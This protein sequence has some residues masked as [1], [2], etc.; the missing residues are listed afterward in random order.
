MSRRPGPTAAAWAAV[1]GLYLVA[2]LVSP[3][4]FQVSQVLNILQVAAF[5][6]LIATGQTLVILIGGIDLAQAGVVTLT[7]IVATSIM[8]GDAGNIPAAVLACLALAALVGMLN[9]LL[10]TRLRITPLVA[11]LAMNAIL[12]GAALVF[13]GGAPRGS[14]AAAFNV[15]GQGS[16][17]GVPLSAI[18]WLGIALPLAFATTRTVWGRQLYATGANPRAAELMGVA[19]ERVQLSA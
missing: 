8:L 17:L 16:V 11:T 12:F 13:T 3:A 6:G 18:V 9:G 14:A 15:I 1:V 10:V 7:N 4:M 5:L 19:V 2:G